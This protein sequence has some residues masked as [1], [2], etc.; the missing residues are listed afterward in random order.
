MEYL[1]IEGFARKMGCSRQTVYNKMSDG[2]IKT[3]QFAT[4]TL[5]PESEAQR[6]KFIKGDY[7]NRNR[8]EEK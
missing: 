2:K 6:L 3:K 4:W 8:I 5:I 1:T 7:P